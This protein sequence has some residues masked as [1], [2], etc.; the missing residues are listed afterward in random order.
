MTVARQ[1]HISRSLEV[2]VLTPLAVGAVAV[3]IAVQAVPSVAGRFVQLL[4]EEAFVGETVAVAG[5]GTD[6]KYYNHLLL[7]G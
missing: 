6:H 3:L 1:T 2:V 7:A 5:C 4:V